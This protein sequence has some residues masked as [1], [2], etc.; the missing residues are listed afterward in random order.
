MTVVL[1]DTIGSRLI[2]SKKPWSMTESFYAFSR[3]LLLKGKAQ[4]SRPPCINMFTLSA[5]LRVLTNSD[6]LL[7]IMKLHFS[8]LQNN[9]S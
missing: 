5:N 7:F 4:Y 2:L 9:L 3:K 8:I 6:Q 1:I